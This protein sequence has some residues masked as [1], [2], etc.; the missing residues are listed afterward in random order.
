[1][2]V[3][4]TQPSEFK[5]QKCQPSLSLILKQIILENFP[6]VRLHVEGQRHQNYKGNPCP[7]VSSLSGRNVYTNCRKGPNE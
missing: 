6:S 4:N 5:T 3:S 2:A 7:R 1:M